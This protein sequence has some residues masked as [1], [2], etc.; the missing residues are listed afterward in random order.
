M[1]PQNPAKLNSSC[2]QRW[3]CLLCVTCSLVPAALADNSPHQP[4]GTNGTNG[5]RG[6]PVVLTG[7][8]GR[9]A[10]NRSIRRFNRQVRR[11]QINEWQSA[12]PVLVN[13]TPVTPEVPQATVAPKAS[14]DELLAAKL[15]NQL[16]FDLYR[17]MR[18]GDGNKFFSPISIS[19]ALALTLAA[20]GGETKQQI[21]GV[22]HLESPE[23]Q[24]HT[25]LGGLVRRLNAKQTNTL[26]LANRLWVQRGFQ[27][28]P[29]FLHLARDAY[30][31]ELGE[32][33]FVDPNYARQSIN[34]WVEQATAGHIRELIPTGLLTD[35]VRLVFTSA[36]YFKGTWK[37]RFVPTSTQPLDFHLAADRSVKL[38]T[39]QQTGAFRYA[40]TEHVK[41]LDLPYVG[42][43]L[44]MIILLP[45]K[46]DGL[47]DL[48]NKLTLPEV[49]KLITQIHDEDEVE[50]RLPK[51]KFT[52]QTGLKEILSSLG[53]PLAFGN[54]ADFSQL[55]NQK[56]Q[57]LFDFLHE[58]YVDVNEEGTEAAAV[59]GFIGGDL[60]G[61]V[62]Q[63][64]YFHAD[65]PFLF[66]IQDN[67][68]G[69]IL[70]LGRVNNPN[71]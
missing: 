68:T 42:E 1:R 59:T 69:A 10:E 36:I 54:E 44:S 49:Q 55:T 18:D 46:R 28:E 34:S 66:L 64:R 26:T 17:E 30:G 7:Y 16:A 47:A 61:P 15:N 13:T 21:A 37:Y 71:G 70:F 40:D 60:P 67:R 56:A 50:I 5:G 33:D 43:Q 6:M 22:L 35:E 52:A 8:A 39:M 19:T 2:L 20:A 11:G 27:F 45:K 57:K 65:H 62:P 48:E 32:T 12:P 9:R 53:M 38:P 3:V 24:Y 63:T 41:L 23:A 31:S 51:F 4:R 29:A 25:G 14:E 58:A